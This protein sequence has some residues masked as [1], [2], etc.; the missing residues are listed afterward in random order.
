MKTMIAIAA[1]CL[2]GLTPYGAGG[3]ETGTM[4]CRGGIVSVG[5]AIPTVLHKCGPPA[6]ATQREQSEVTGSTRR[7]GTKTITRI[8]IDDWTYNFGPNEFMYQVIFE[9]G[10]VARIESLDWGF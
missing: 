9:N 1:A 7:G 3:S 8:T 10:R 6:Y 5:D 4:V 2:L